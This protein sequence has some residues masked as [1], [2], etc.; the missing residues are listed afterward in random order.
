M[1]CKICKKEIENYPCQHCGYDNSE[2]LNPNYLSPG[3]ELQN[4]KYVVGQVIGA[5]GFGV[6]YSAWDTLL[7]R[8]VAIKEYMPGEFSTRMPGRT[9]LTI[10]S[11]EKETQFNDGMLKFYDESNRLAKF[12]ETAGIVQIYDCFYE[13]NTAY[14]VMEYLDGMTLAERIEQDGRIP[15]DEAVQIIASVLETLE[16]VHKE[17]I[18]HRD[19]APNNI[20]LTNDGK[21]KLLDFGAARTATGSHSKSLTVLYKE[22]YTAEEQYRSNGDQGPWTDVYSAAATFYK[23]VTGITPDGAMERR[24]KDELKPIR[25]CG[26][27]IP[28]RI[29]KAVMNALNVSST[30]R[31]QTAGQFRDELTVIKNVK[32]NYVRTRER[33]VGRFPIAIAVLSFFIASAGIALFA[34]QQLGYITF[35]IDIWGN[36]FVPEGKVRM[37]NVVNMNMYEAEAELEKLGLNMEVSETLYKDDVF[38]GI[39]L[40]QSTAKGKVIDVGTTI[41]VSVNDV[42]HEEVIEEPPVRLLRSERS[43]GTFITYEYDSDWN[44]VRKNYSS[45]IFDM[46]EYDSDGKAT[47]EANSNGLDYASDITYEYDS[48]G[49]VI[50]KSEWSYSISYEWDEGKVNNVTIGDLWDD[51]TVLEEYQFDEFGNITY[52]RFDGPWM[53][54]DFIPVDHSVEIGDIFIDDDVDAEMTFEYECNEDGMMRSYTLVIKQYTPGYTLS[55]IKLYT[56]YDQCGNEIY[57]D[58]IESS[59]TFNNFG[60]RERIYTTNY[61]SDGTETSYER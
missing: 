42:L 34:L 59:N 29:E 53:W 61:Y 41:Y 18:I 4:G 58:G 28:S 24:L 54:T 19:I 48:F 43:D 6:T 1:N 15:V 12:T 31:T 10:Y 26:V 22:G 40:S 13:N 3:S 25:K 49:N 35:D 50:K 9:Q 39:I 7:D 27:K 60:G 23:A 33:K 14:I 57:C 44:L 56:V 55:T 16:L 36:L 46:F 5:G 45:G 30:K 20:F 52:M 32:N 21:V 38:A 37:I 11:G 8:H 2:V 47:N 17:K 51:E